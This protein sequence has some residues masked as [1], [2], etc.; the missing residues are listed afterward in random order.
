MND[1]QERSRDLIFNGPTEDIRDYAVCVLD[2]IN[3]RLR[4]ANAIGSSPDEAS[5]VF[6]IKAM[7]R[8]LD[9]QR[10]TIAD[11]RKASQ[12]KKEVNK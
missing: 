4:I 7:F 9:R 8:Q 6:G 2:L 5:I 1:L 11:L 12:F 10:K 3:E